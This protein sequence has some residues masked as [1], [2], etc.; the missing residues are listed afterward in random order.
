M[1][2][3]DFIIPATL[4]VVL[5]A[6]GTLL[7][8]TTAVAA[9]CTFPAPGKIDV[10]IDRLDG[11]VVLNNE[12]SRD[13]LSRMQSQSGRANA[14]GSAWTP[15]G[16]TLTELTYKMRL[17]LEALP[18]SNGRYCARLTNLDAE[19]GYDKLK[20]YIARK[21]RPGSCAYSSINEHEM[22]H[23]AVFRQALDDYFPRLQRSLDR[24]AREL[25]PVL[26]SSPD[27]AGIYLRKRLNATV[28]SLFLEMNRVLDRNNA[29]LDTP[30]RYRL[31]QAR[32]KDW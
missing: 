13:S 31:E 12:R 10:R 17:K 18:L 2:L 14:L 6:C 22:T 32:C 26:A 9:E 8:T 20:V 29:L 23:V 7:V 28:Q 30:E 4:A 15:V 1:K 3:S 19:L 25:Q 5:A 24:A 27:Q 11:Q 21:F 16:L